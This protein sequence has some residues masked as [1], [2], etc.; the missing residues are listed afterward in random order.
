MSDFDCDLSN[1]WSAII[2]WPAVVIGWLLKWTFLA[3]TVPL[4]LPV[5]LIVRRKR[6]RGEAAFAR[7]ARGNGKFAPTATSTMDGGAF[8]FI[9]HR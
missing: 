2:M 9:P 1:A 5:M 6:Q 3:A 4:W 7:L 8:P